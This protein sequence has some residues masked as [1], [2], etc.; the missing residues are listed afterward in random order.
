MDAED[1]P[2]RSDEDSG[3]KKSHKP[4][5]GGQWGSPPYFLGTFWID[6]AGSQAEIWVETREALEMVQASVKSGLV[7]ESC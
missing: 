7:G 3:R 1:A 6:P 2:D 5:E 4:G